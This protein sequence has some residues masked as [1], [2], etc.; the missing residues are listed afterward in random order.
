MKKTTLPL[1][2][3]SI[4]S[5]FCF[6]DQQADSK[7]SLKGLTSVGIHVDELPNDALRF[8]LRAEELSVLVKHILDKSDVKV[9]TET[10][11]LTVPGKPYLNVS[12]NLLANDKNNSCAL[13]LE[14]SLW[15]E[16]KLVRDGKLE[17]ISVMTWKSRGLTLIQ[18]GLSLP[19]VQSRLS[20]YVNEFIK[21]WCEANNNPLPKDKK[22]MSV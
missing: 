20:D 5:A 11:R 10:D 13:M 15:Q 6:A 4:F 14:L 19:A 7:L 17:S 9:L 12:I 18:P 8:G 16:V 3:L 22:K 2:A 1:I 21:D